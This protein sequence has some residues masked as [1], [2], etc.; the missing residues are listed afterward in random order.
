MLGSIASSMLNKTTF[1]I[2][3]PW[4][5]RFFMFPEILADYRTLEKAI[6]AI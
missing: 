5:L 4:E 1:V 3:Q 6:D 2:L